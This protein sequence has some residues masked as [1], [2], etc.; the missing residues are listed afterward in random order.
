MPRRGRCFNGIGNFVWAS[1]SGRE[2]DRGSH[3]KF[4]RGEKGTKGRVRLLQ[5]RS[6]AE[7]GKVA[8]GFPTQGLWLRDRIV[9]SQIISKD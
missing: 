8:S 1:G 4:S 2:E 6:L 5:A 9:G 3:K 7:L